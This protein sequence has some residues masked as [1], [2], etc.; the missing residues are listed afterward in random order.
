MN[1]FIFVIRKLVKSLVNNFL[2]MTPKPK[3]K[4]SFFHT[5]RSVT[6]EATDLILDSE[7][8]DVLVESARSIREDQTSK[9]SEK[10]LK[11]KSVLRRGI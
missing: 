11:F 4:I 5:V 9:K 10:N 7:D 3:R 8:S 2:T 1:S 6:S